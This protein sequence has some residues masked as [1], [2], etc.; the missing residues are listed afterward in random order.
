MWLIW[1]FQ[2][3]IFAD[4]NK[5]FLGVCC[6]QDHSEDLFFQG[7]G[8]LCISNYN[9]F[10][11]NECVW[12]DPFQLYSICL[13]GGRWLTLLNIPSECCWHLGKQVYA[14]LA[15]QK[16]NYKHLDECL[17]ILNVEIKHNRFNNVIKCSELKSESKCEL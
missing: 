15:C 7:W 14:V 3:V 10:I 17:K 12:M 11:L 9:V 8:I 13:L 4:L 5:P 2:I 1:R 6:L 16:F